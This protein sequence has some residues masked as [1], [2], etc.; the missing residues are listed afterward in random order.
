[1]I[2]IGIRSPRLCQY[3][4]TQLLCSRPRYSLVQY[5]F[6][7]GKKCKFNRTLYNTQLIQFAHTP[8]EFVVCFTRYQYLVKV[9]TF[10]TVAQYLLLISLYSFRVQCLELYTAC[11]LSQYHWDKAFHFPDFTFSSKQSLTQTDS[12]QFTCLVFSTAN[13]VMFCEI[14]LQSAAHIT[15]D[16]RFIYFIFKFFLTNPRSLIPRS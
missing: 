11:I 12:H 4:Y 3:K 9:I 7:T 10:S 13:G 8:A 6:S 14:Y 5:M 15:T 1:M 16:P 2:F